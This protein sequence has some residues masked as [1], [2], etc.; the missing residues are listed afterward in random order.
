[1][2]FYDETV[3]FGDRRQSTASV[4][5]ADANSGGRAVMSEAGNMCIW[6][7]VMSIDITAL[8]LMMK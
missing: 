3:F 8:T 7:E 4:M 6:L 1:M 5:S 2:A